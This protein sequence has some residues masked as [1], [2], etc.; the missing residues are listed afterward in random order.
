MSPE[1][2]LN[3]QILIVLAAR[4]MDLISPDCHLQKG[5][6]YAREQSESRSMRSSD[7]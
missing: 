3:D 1:I 2:T 7:L 5:P 6:K 4:N